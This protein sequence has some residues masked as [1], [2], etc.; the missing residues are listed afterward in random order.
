MENDDKRWRHID[1]K[2]VTADPARIKSFVDIADGGEGVGA[3]RIEI[4]V[5][6]V[7]RAWFRRDLPNGPV[8]GIEQEHLS[9][10]DFA[11]NDIPRRIRFE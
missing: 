3:D 5:H 6:V 2:G 1:H 4:P 9:P 7:R 10:P 11:V 8:A